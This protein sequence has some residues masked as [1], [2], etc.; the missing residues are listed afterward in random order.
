MV[1]GALCSSLLGLTQAKTVFV[2][3]SIL[4]SDNGC[5]FVNKLIEEVASTWSGRPHINLN[6]KDWLKKLIT[7]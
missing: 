2:L 3:P 1:S 5:E 6:H 4:N 7:P